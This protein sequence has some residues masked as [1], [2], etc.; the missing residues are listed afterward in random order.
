M[1]TSDTP[2]DIQARVA[3]RKAAVELVEYLD[4][5]AHSEHFWSVLG[6]LVAAR[7]PK[8]QPAPT[9]RCL[10]PLS[11]DEA[12]RFEAQS[13]PFNLGAYP[14]GTKIRD[15]ARESLEWLDDVSAFTRN[16]RRYLRR[17]QP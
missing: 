14:R 3:A 9:C 8:P 12:R 1:S 17:S 15:V 11:D 13:L 4:A 2:N 7:A 10:I 16:L 5:E 6:E